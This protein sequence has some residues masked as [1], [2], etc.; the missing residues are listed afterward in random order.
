MTTCRLLRKL[1]EQ[2]I[3]EAKFG[4]GE[5]HPFK[6]GGRVYVSFDKKALTNLSS[7]TQAGRVGGQLETITQLGAVK[8]FGL[9][10]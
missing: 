8:G 6:L 1:Y 4:Q 9:L 3:L 5:F 7:L 10:R 2:F